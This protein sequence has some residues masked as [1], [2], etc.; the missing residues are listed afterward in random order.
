VGIPKTWKLFND[1]KALYPIGYGLT[2][3]LIQNFTKELKTEG[4]IVLTPKRETL[5]RIRHHTSQ[6]HIELRILLL[7]RGAGSTPD[8]HGAVLVLMHLARNKGTQVGLC[9][10]EGRTRKPHDAVVPL[11]MPLEHRKEISRG[12]MEIHPAEI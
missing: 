3:L 10:G 5:P 8:R 9:K 2:I 1:I 6:P 4:W 7:R 12:Y 11:L